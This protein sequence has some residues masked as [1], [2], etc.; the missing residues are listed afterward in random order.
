M[1]DSHVRIVVRAALEDLASARQAWGEDSPGY[2]E[3]RE[4]SLGFLRTSLFRRSRIVA[5]VLDAPEPLEPT[6]RLQRGREQRVDGTVA[7]AVERLGQI[8]AAAA[9]A[10]CPLMGGTVYPDRAFGQR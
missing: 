2:R 5:P 4:R 7:G 3:Q 9:R 1:N 8:E 10:P 6:D